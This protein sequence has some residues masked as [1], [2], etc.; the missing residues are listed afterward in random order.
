MGSNPTRPVVSWK[1]F[2]SP[3][4][5]Y[6]ERGQMSFADK[7]RNEEKFTRTENGAVALNT[8]G[9]ARLDLFGSIGSLRATDDNRIHTLFVEAYRQDPLAAVRI[10]FYARDIR[11]GLG[12]RE[13]FRK[14]LKYAADHH[15]EAIRPNLDLIGVFGRYDD[16]YAMIGTRLEDD[17][18][19]TM[20]RQFEEDLT[21]LYEG[22][23]IS[24]LAKWI[25]TAD[26]HSAKT[27]ELGIQTANRMGYPVYNFKRIVRSMRKRIG[28]VEGLLSAGRWDE[29]EYPAV[30]SRAMKLY[31]NAFMR[32]DKVHYQKYLDKVEK[33]EAKINAGALY[34][35]DIIE[36]YLH[37]GAWEDRTLEAQW[38]AL[39]DY[40]EKGVNALVMADTSGSMNG[41][42]LATSVGLAIYFAERN[43]GEYKD[44]FLT[45]SAEPEIIRLRGETLLQKLLNAARAPWGMNT[46]L[47]AAFELVLDLAVKGNVSPEEMPKAIVVISD[48]EI[49]RC[50][51]RQWTF[52]EKMAAKFAK[53]GYVI[54]NIVF[55][56]VN[57][58]HD[59]FHADA[60]RRG[61][62]LASG[63]SV[64]VFKR[65]LENIGCD[66]VE[67]MEKVIN[68]E[69]YAP[70]AV[71]R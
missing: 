6:E 24:L 67:A 34:P 42:P 43:T 58:R 12:E 39:P 9:D 3:E 21:D 31:R 15:P 37:R 53:K 65:I 68:S 16:L 47:C 64:T 20:K 22:K 26:S 8:S 5:E 45:F 49:D 66:P 55:W 19:A 14:I 61:V 7:L 2:D 46:D 57:S 38:K 36:Q 23:A 10:L 51:N 50:G 52:Y 13:T 33:G 40:V 32:H 71:E 60:R 28:V 41:R 29:I 1:W 11:E 27:R 30:P 63:Q 35:Y 69:R 18:W 59:I 25:K 70:I 48:M 54:P 56:N 4:R 44:L 62:Q 17:M